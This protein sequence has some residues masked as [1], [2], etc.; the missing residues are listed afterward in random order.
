[1]S[2]AKLTSA[3][4][5]GSPPATKGHGHRRTLFDDDNWQS[6]RPSKT[7]PDA[8]FRTHPIVSSALS[9]AATV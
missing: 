5:A 9:E 6:S 7:T 1:M 4:L 3:R 8:F 2:Y